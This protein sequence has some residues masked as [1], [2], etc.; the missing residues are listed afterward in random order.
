VQL[1]EAAGFLGTAL[2]G[3]AYIPQI[4][5]LITAHCSAG[6]SRLAFGVWSVASLLVTSHAVATGAEV[7]TVL[8]VLQLVATSVIVVYSTKYR[9]S[10]CEGH[11]S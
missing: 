1:T 10:L 2:A 11:R 4:W 3:A 6:I 7:F 9:H 8:G 5:H